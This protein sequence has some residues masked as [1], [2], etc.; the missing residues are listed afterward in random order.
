MRLRGL[1]LIAS[2]SGLRLAWLPLLGLI[3]PRAG[4]SLRL[5]ILRLSGLGLW[6]CIFNLSGLRL[7][8]L[9][10]RSRLR[11]P[12]LRLWLQS[13]GPRLRKS[14]AHLL[15]LIASRTRLH[16][17]LRNL[18]LEPAGDGR[19]LSRRRRLRLKA[20][21]TRLNLRLR[22]LWLWSS[23]TGLRLLP[24]PLPALQLV[25]LAGPGE[26]LRLSVVK[27]R[28]WRRQHNSWQHCRYRAIRNHRA[29]AYYHRRTPLIPVVKLLPVLRSFP[30]HLHLR[31]HGLVSLF[32]EHRNFRGYRPILPA[33]V[34]A[35]EAH[36]IRNPVIHDHVVDYHIMDVNVMNHGHIHA[37]DSGVVAKVIVVPIAAIVAVADIAVAVVDTTI[38]PNVQS[39]EAMVEA[40][41]IARESPVSGSP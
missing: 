24:W 40:I 27:T 9:T 1:R 34:S 39:P 36:V 22:A 28:L 25:R 38:E 16:L 29:R 32:V 11:L 10:S 30:L 8:L 14:R 6:L 35:V 26:V 20:S 5:C 37:I 31:R 18:R 2:R 19:R 17:R 33:T 12:R 7:G 21:R 4:L 41:A 23:G 3:A 15:W 13:S